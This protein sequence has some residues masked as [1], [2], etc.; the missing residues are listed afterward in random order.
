MNLIVDLV[1]LAILLAGLILGYK[2]G[3]VKTVAKPVKLVAVWVCTIKSCSAFAARF[4]APL[5]QT[6]VTEKLSEFLQENYKHIT[7]SNAS[8]ELPTLLKI[9][10]G[11]FNI[12][13]QQVAEDAGAA[14]TQK[15]AET[16]T[17][18]LVSLASIVIAFVVLLIV[19]SVLVFSNLT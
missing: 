5:I 18:P 15:L 17:A 11:L 3:F 12:D 16:F 19:F 10:A 7:E 13:I 14:L 6:S 8:E 4:I 9:A 1:L 2:R